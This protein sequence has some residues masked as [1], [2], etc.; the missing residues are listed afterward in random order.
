METKTCSRC[1]CELPLDQFYPHKAKVSTHK[2][3]FRSICKSCNTVVAREYRQKNRQRYNAKVREYAQR[4]RLLVLSHY[5]GGIEPI[6][7]ECGFTDIRALSIDHINGGGNQ[8]R[9]SLGDG[10]CVGPQYVY[11]WLKN[12]GF[13]SGYQ[14]LCM[15]CQFIKKVERHEH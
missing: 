15:N 11:Q 12:N 2:A 9:R 13:P 7:C 1:N 5:C 3:W 6:C 8:H 4:L 14:V 10:L